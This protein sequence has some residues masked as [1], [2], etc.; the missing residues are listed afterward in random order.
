[1]ATFIIRKIVV[2]NAGITLILLHRLSIALI[3]AFRITR[4]PKILS[5]FLDPRYG[6]DV[7]R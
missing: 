6:I 2:L 4:P 3:P 7:R 1:V 5:N